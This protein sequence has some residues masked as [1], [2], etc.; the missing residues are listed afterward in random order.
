[1]FKR[2][3][4]FDLKHP[5]RHA[6]DAFARLRQSGEAEPKLLL[7]MA[8]TAS[9]SNT[10]LRRSP[11]RSSNKIGTASCRERACPNVYCSV[12]AGTLKKKKQIDT[13]VNVKRRLH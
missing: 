13:I 1:M 8:S 6:A 11:V 9:A 12:A 4:K 10:R 3:Q 5:S 2:D 7:T